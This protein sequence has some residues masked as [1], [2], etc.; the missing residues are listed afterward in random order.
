VQTPASEGHNV[1]SPSPS[2]RKKRKTFQEE[3]AEA[4]G[5][6]I[7]PRRRRS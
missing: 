7:S 5:V 6:M 3:Y 4:I 1:G 2:P